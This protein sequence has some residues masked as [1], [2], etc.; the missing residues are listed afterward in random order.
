MKNKFVIIVCTII[1]ILFLGGILSFNTLQ[2]SN[3]ECDK[4]WAQVENQMQRRNDLIPNIVSTVKGYAKHEENIFNNIAEARA[5]LLSASTPSETVQ[6]NNE[7]SS[8]LGRLLAISENY[9]T[10]KA[11]VHYSE[12][13]TELEGSENRISVAR[14]DYI[15]VV[16]NYNVRIST[17]PGNIFATMFNFTPKYQFTAEENAKQVPKIEF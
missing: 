1:G 4:A 9:P 10:L 7:L 15:Q 6:A 11:D 12:L 14:R 17:F 13:I 2:T 3:L 16:N 8:A 5:K